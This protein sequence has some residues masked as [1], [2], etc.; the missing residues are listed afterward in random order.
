M[1]ELRQAAEMALHAL[2]GAQDAL[3]DWGAYVNEYFKRKHNFDGD[4]ANVQKAIDALRA[5]LE[6]NDK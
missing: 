2:Q 6:N 5:A 1:P 4:V 3:L